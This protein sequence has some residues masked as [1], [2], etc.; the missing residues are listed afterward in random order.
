MCPLG[1]STVPV[2][3]LFSYPCPGIASGEKQA[4]IAD[5]LAESNEI[6]QLTL[7]RPLDRVSALQS[8]G[9]GHVSGPGD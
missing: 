2:A 1:L 8:P 4:L 7:K 9:F 5:Q 6:S 3:A